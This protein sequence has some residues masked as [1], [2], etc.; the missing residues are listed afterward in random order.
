MNHQNKK[1]GYR[2]FWKWILGICVVILLTTVGYSYSIYHSFNKNFEK[3]QI[4]HETKKREKEVSIK[5]VDP[6]SVLLLGVDERKNDS[7]RSDTII[8]LTANPQ[9][10]DMKMVSI[11]RD[12]YTAIVGKG[13]ID[14]LNH[15]YAFGGI[16]MASDSVEA[17]LNI[18][19]DYIAEVNMEGFKD[20]VDA[21][22]GITVKNTLAFKQ[23]N[24][25][26]PKGT[27]TLDGD[28]T[29]K[30]VRMRKEDPRGDF[31]RQDRQKQVISGIL[32]ES[33]STKTLTNYDK[34]FTA[35]GKNVQTS[36]TLADITSLQKNYKDS[37]NNIDQI[38][39]KKGKGEIIDGIWYYKMN[40]K[41]LASVSK[42][43]RHHLELPDNDK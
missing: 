20:L 36:L 41:E 16:E 40:Q 17:L 38:T 1:K 23:D 29:L 33:V 8:V 24:Y 9:T 14:K 11:P 43:L 37:I 28:S 2:R 32:K 26:F 30:Y 4:K 15:A 6:V 5:H 18:P 31:G 34:I 3:T 35:L 21:V 12:T 25:N 27:I 42:E 19:I 13:T 22:D 7:G 10:K 39:F